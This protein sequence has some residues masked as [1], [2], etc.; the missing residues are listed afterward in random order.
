M[1]FILLSSSSPSD[2]SKNVQ[3]YLDD[4]WE[5]HGT[6]NMVAEMTYSAWNECNTSHSVYSQALIKKEA[7]AD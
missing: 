7:V 4:G 1:K 2:L 5:L 3:K 6:T